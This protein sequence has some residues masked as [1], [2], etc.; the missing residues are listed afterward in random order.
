M[1]ADTGPLY[2]MW[3]PDDERHRRATE[4][5]ARVG[6]EGLTVAVPYPVLL[7]A[8][9]LVMRKLRLDEARG[10][11]DELEEKYPFVVAGAED[12]RAAAVAVRRYPTRR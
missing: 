10:F 2:A 4:E 11:L 1:V 12:H 6:E 3:D 7:E 9:T 8:Y 5:I